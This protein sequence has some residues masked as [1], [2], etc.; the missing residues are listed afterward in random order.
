MKFI[1]P[2]YL[3]EKGQKQVREYFEENCEA[4]LVNFLDL[5]KLFK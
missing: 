3:T 1:N 2:E 5:E 4:L